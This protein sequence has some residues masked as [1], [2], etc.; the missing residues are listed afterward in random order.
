MADPLPQAKML[1][2]LAITRPRTAIEINACTH[3]GLRPVGVVPVGLNATELLTPR[4]GSSSGQAGLRPWIGWTAVRSLVRINGYELEAQLLGLLDEPYQ[5][6]LIGYLAGQHCRAR[7]PLQLHAVKQ[8]SERIA[9]LPA[10]DDP[11]PA[12]SGLVA[13][14]HC[15][16]HI[17]AGDLSSPSGRIHLGETAAGAAR[18]RTPAR[19]RPGSESP[20]VPL[21]RYTTSAGSPDSTG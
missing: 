19:A 17:R 7:K 11:V 2:A 16:A 18:A 21:G 20:I 4:Y 15:E 14:H 1:T 13:V 12:A 10:K 3:C 9:Q 5:V 6:R 8:E